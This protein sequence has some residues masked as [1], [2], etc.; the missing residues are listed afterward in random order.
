MLTSD[1]FNTKIINRP[2]KEPISKAYS[3]K[4]PINKEKLNWSITDGINSDDE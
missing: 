3:E 2:I 1:Y 4:V